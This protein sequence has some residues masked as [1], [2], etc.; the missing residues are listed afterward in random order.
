[1]KT[2]KETKHVTWGIKPCV[3]TESDPVLQLWLQCGIQH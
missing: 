3:W 1:M 2:K